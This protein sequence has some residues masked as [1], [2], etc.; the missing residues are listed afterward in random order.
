MNYF[1][2]QTE[3]TEKMRTDAVNL[4]ITC[5]LENKIHF[6]TIYQAVLLM[7][8]YL[9]LDKVLGKDLDI[10]ALSCFYLSVKIE[11][12]YDL[13]SINDLEIK[14]NNKY[15]Q[16]EF[17]EVEN[18]ILCKL[19]FKI[20][21]STVFEYLK[22]L[23]VRNKFDKENFCMSMYLSLLTLSTI[24]Y[25]FIDPLKLA[26]KIN[27]FCMLLLMPTKIIEELVNNDP[28]YSYFYFL[29][30][31]SSESESCILK[32][33]FSDKKFFCIGMRSVPKILSKNDKMLCFREK[34]KKIDVNDNGYNH[35][36]YSNEWNNIKYIKH[37]GSGTY[38][39]VVHIKISDNDIALKII[40]TQNTDK[41]IDGLILRELYALATLDHP[42]II[43]I[44]FFR[45]NCQKYKMYIGLELMQMT[46]HHKILNNFIDEKTKASYII[47]LLKGLTYIH[48]KNIIH[49]DISVLNVLISNDNIIKISDFGS[50]KYIRHPNYIVNHSIDVCTSYFR[51]IE[52][53][54]GK[55]LYTQEIDVWSCACV[56]GFILRGRY[57]FVGNDTNSLISNILEILGTPEDLYIDKFCHYPRFHKKKGFVDLEKTYQKQTNILYKMLDYDP[58]KRISAA[59]ALELFVESYSDLLKN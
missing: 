18:D 3:I 49:R 22:S 14:L 40:P 42:N 51:A 8:R 15:S 48:S 31:K 25:R 43:K 24:D 57:L 21:D 2:H 53:F 36:F 52:I 38:G 29:L 59:E 58:N 56:I 7:D 41:S 9:S 44:I 17:L 20:Y 4:I 37:I 12:D 10:I 46:L 19:N 30:Q 32:K 16:E 6:Y 1:D 54:A 33:K 55:K 27:A 26:K 5:S 50:S 34:Y 11:E 28:V 45:Y 13:I 35:L 39:N 23:Y 47:Q